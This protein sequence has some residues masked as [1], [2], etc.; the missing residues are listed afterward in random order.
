MRFLTTDL[1]FFIC[2]AFT[3]VCCLIFYYT[4]RKPKKESGKVFEL[5]LFNMLLTCVASI[6]AT[7]VNP[8]VSTEGNAFNV[9]QHFFQTIYFALH[10]LL[11]PLFA[12]YVAIVNNW[13]E[14]YSKRVVFWFLS[15]ALLLE[16]FVLTNPLTHLIFYYQDNVLFTRGPLELFIYAE[17][18]GY[19]AFAVVQLFTYRRILAKSTA[20]A[21]WFFIGASLAGILVQFVLPWLKFELFFESIS[22]LGVMILIEMEELHADSITGVYNRRTFVAD[23]DRFIRSK[24]KY[25]VIVISFLSFRD[26]RSVFKIEDLEKVTQSLLF[27][28]LKNSTGTVYR[29]AQDKVAIVSS[30]EKNACENF[31]ARFLSVLSDGE[32]RVGGVSVS[33]EAKCSV[34]TVPDEV[35]NAEWLAELGEDGNVK[36]SVERIELENALERAVR[37]R[38]FEILYQPI[39]NSESSFF[40]SAEALVR[41]DDPVFANFSP[42]EFIPIAER[43]GFANDIG[44]IVF[45]NVCRFVNERKPSLCGLREIDVNVSASQFFPENC[46]GFFRNTLEKY[47]VSAGFFELE[48]SRSSILDENEI[49]IKNFRKLRNLGFLFSLDDFGEGYANWNRVLDGDFRSVKLGRKRLQESGKSAFSKTLQAVRE[50]L[51]KN[52][53]NVVQKGIETHEHLIE[54]RKTGANRFQGMYFSKPLREDALI[55]FLKSRNEAARLLSRRDLFELS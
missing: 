28:I 24:R 52:H 51:R 48:I 26:L 20:F 43:R 17:A 11:A 13:G 46:E 55:E 6:F 16:F 30:Q 1:C 25:S 54:S 19:I 29:L 45:E 34:V 31:S 22:L 9:V 27:W 53:V 12:L 35:G 4:H 50:I 44:R 40:D 10:T 15:P 36:A 37:E 21:L 41:L 38:K 42:A 18:A 7:G 23:N 32:Y 47:G 5:I 2:S 33:I 3:V 8:L 14:N 49:A 39:W